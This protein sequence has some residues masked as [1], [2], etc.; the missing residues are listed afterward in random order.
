MNKDMT[1][2]EEAEV[3][4]PVFKAGELV[5][6]KLGFKALIHGVSSEIRNEQGT[7][8]QELTSQELIYLVGYLDNNGKME[9][10]KVNYPVLERYVD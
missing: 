5:R 10:I 4:V 1:L 8:V 3:E 9:F 7:V 2:G 6:H